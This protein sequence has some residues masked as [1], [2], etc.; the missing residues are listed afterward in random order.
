MHQQDSTRPLGLPELVDQAAAQVAGVVL[1]A[2]QAGHV[3][4]AT[5]ITS[6]QHLWR[7]SF[8][9]RHT[10][11][12]SLDNFRARRGAVADAT[13]DVPRRV[14]VVLLV[15]LTVKRDLGW[16]SRNL[17]ATSGPAGEGWQVVH[18]SVHPDPTR[19]LASLTGHHDQHEPVTPPRRSR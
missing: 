3:P 4:P 17:L 1:A 18:A 11:A 19:L 2:V 8:Q 7:W 10:P 14:A 15:D 13:P 9:L 16:L 5:V 6:E 12:H